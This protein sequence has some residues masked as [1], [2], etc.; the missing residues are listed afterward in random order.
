MLAIRY[1]RGAL[2]DIEGARDWWKRNRDKAPTALADSIDT[3]VGL[4]ADA[5]DIGV[6][7]RGP[8]SE[9]VRRILLPRVRYHLYYRVIGDPATSVDILSLRHTSR[10]ARFV[11]E[12]A[13]PYV[14][15]QA[16]AA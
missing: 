15:L 2:R 8:M 14:E 12:H 16:C 9:G 5:P 4:I 6:P 13:V 3:V 1:T 7:C 11:R 10:A